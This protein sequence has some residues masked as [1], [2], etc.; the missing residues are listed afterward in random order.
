MAV[1]TERGFHFP[2]RWIFLNRLKESEV[3]LPQIRQYSTSEIVQIAVRYRNNLWAL[4]SPYNA[5]D[6][7]SLEGRVGVQKTILEMA[8]QKNLFRDANIKSPICINEVKPIG[9][10]QVNKLLE[11]YKDSRRLFEDL[12]LSNADW[13]FGCSPEEAKTYTTTLELACTL[14]ELGQEG[15][16]SSIDGQF[17]RDNQID[18]VQMRSTGH[19]ELQ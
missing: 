9:R 14:S 3:K 6:R 4:K 5:V 18:W 8:G 11:L 16:V 12:D 2:S 15:L 1:I 10:A 7:A 17:G 19:G 13:P